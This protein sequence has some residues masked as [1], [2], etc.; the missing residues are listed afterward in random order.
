MEKNESYLI[1]LLKGEKP[2]FIVFW[3]WFIAISILIE[4]FFETDFIQNNYVENKNSYVE[5]ILYFFILIYS[6]IIFAIVYKSSNKYEGSKVWSFL[7]KVLVTINLFFS[8]TL[9]MDLSKYYFLEDYEIQKQ[10]D[11]FKVSLPMRIDL[12]TIFL[13]IY[14][15]EKTIY[16]LY[17]LLQI[18]IENDIQKNKFTKQIQNSLCEDTHNLD[19]LKKD[20]ILDYTYI[21][22]KEEEITNIVTSKENCGKSIYDLEILNEILQKQGMNER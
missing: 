20:Y 2:L 19:L 1:K 16:Y 3:F 9:F 5:L 15:E 21:N 7:A 12:N 13:D 6:I 14:K 10:I 4:L 11:D 8:L 22:E 18:N 17:Q